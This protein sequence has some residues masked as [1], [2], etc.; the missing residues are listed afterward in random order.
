M[1]DTH[2]TRAVNGTVALIVIA[3]VAV[4]VEVVLIIVAVVMQNKPTSVWHSTTQLWFTD[5]DSDCRRW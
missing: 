3:L 4:L 2:V 5:G 1:A